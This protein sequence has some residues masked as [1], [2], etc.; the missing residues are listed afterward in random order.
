M[1][2][3]NSVYSPDIELDEDGKIFLTFLERFGHTRGIVDGYNN[4]I[5]NIISLVNNENK[6]FH[7][8]EFTFTFR[9]ARIIRPEI[10]PIE[11]FESGKGSYFLQLLADL[12]IT[13][14]RLPGEERIIKGI[15][16]GYV[17][18]MIGSAYDPLFRKRTEPNVF[19]PGEIAGED[20]AEPDS[21][22]IINGKYMVANM[23]D[24]LIANTIL[25]YTK[26]TK[27]ELNTL[28]SAITTESRQGKTA[29]YRIHLK[30]GILKYDSFREFTSGE[31]SE[32][33]SLDVLDT[34][35]LLDY[36]EEKEKNGPLEDFIIS[37]TRPEWRDRIRM[38]LSQSM[39]IHLQKEEKTLIEELSVITAAAKGLGITYFRNKLRKELYSHIGVEPEYDESKQALLAL[40]IVRLLEAHLGL[41][42]LDD[43]NSYSNKRFK[44]IGGSMFHL[45]GIFLES[46][47]ATFQGDYN[48]SHTDDHIRADF[49]DHTI[50]E[51]YVQSFEKSWGL[52]SK[53][54]AKK[55]VFVEKLKNEQFMLQ[56][57]HVDKVVRNRDAHSKDY[58]IRKVHG[59]Q[60]R[61]IC[62]GET[63]ES[64]K[65]GLNNT[66]ASLEYNSQ[67]HDDREIIEVI[68]IWSGETIPMVAFDNFQR[69]LVYDSFLV[70]NGIVIGSCIG[71]DVYERLLWSRRRNI[72]PFD[73]QSIYDEED[74][75]VFVNTDG[76]RPVTPC[77]VVEDN[78]I[79]LEEMGLEKEEDVIKILSS[80]AIDF[81][82]PR[83]LEWKVMAFS[84]EEFH[85]KQRAVQQY[86]DRLRYLHSIK[87][88][89]LNGEILFQS[90]QDPTV[91][92]NAETREKQATEEKNR[93]QFLWE[94][95]KKRYDEFLQR[96]ENLVEEGDNNG[97]E[98]R[99]N[100]LVGHLER[101]RRIMDRYDPEKSEL[102]SAD[103]EGLTMETLNRLILRVEGQYKLVQFKSRFDYCDIDPVSLMGITLSILPFSTHNPGPRQTFAC[104]MAKQAMSLPS[105]SMRWNPRSSKYLTY[106]Q[107]SATETQ[108]YKYLKLDTHCIGFTPITA[109]FIGQDTVEDMV[110]VSKGF[111]QRGGAQSVTSKV[112]RNKTSK[113]GREVRGDNSVVTIRMTNELPDKVVGN[114]RSLYRHLGP[115]GIVIVGSVVVE[116]DCLIGKY[117][118]IRSGDSVRFYDMS[119]YVKRSKQGIVESVAPYDKNDDEISIRIQIDELRTPEEGDKLSNAHAQKTTIGTIKDDTEMPYSLE[120]GCIPD[121]IMNSHAHPSRMTIGML[122]EMI[123]GKAHVLSD[124]RYNSTAFRRNMMEEEIEELFRELGF[125]PM[126]KEIYIN[127]DTGEKFSALVFTGLPYYYRLVHEA[128]PK[129]QNR[130]VGAYKL[131]THQPITGIDNVGGMRY[132]E[133][134]FEVL[135]THGLSNLIKEYGT[136][137]SDHFIVYTCEICHSQIY[138]GRERTFFCPKCKRTVTEENILFA[139]STYVQERLRKHMEAMGVSSIYHLTPIGEEA[140]LRQ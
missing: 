63:P 99:F 129:L 119:L 134:E 131:D 93:L 100:E 128:A 68:R 34:F 75:Y 109:V 106:P 70:I 8:N 32:K 130:D 49:D 125:D 28:V 103:K 115:D 5:K 19:S 127:P 2:P 135:M 16:F 76:G 60:P 35:T 69:D 82:G 15:N 64:N 112:I 24:T 46:R 133:M 9:N 3:V 107:R 98:D 61:T 138:H 38:E 48:P 21:I 67:H 84:R 29:L 120:T 104:K 81:V 118:E 6:K 140:S 55:N 74:G 111:I 95:E 83:E 117:K 45:F 79:L 25:N 80:G 37:F 18:L 42:P 114:K 43:R 88:K 44:N 123:F 136:R 122:I 124:K 54:G 96:L 27:G 89:V 14:S 85:S 91:F 47:M 1:F 56:I 126:G 110:K 50:T 31:K 53:T 94:E 132:G 77:L 73:I 22:F 23:N 101:T 116:G 87:S 17:P 11:I 86:E 92:V 13:D 36:N 113:L 20:P 40:H 71:Q 51:D 78:K 10:L 41:R 97:F 4:G 66:K 137:N 65:C 121:I 59:G 39:I 12:V 26:S 62:L 52:K 58:R 108:T 7:F 57:A 139:E 105:F 102:L 90:L 33:V 30:K 72:I